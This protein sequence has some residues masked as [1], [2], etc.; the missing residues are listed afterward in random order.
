MKKN[1]ITEKDNIERQLFIDMIKQELNESSNDKVI[2]CAIEG[3]EATLK[4]FEE[5][6]IDTSRITL[7]DFSEISVSKE[8]ER[9]LVNDL[10]RKA[11][12][13]G[14]VKKGD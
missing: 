3:M 13:L 7:K 6:D 11:K 14:Y 9:E 4:W 1:E 12:K 5:N 8:E 10:K 2:Y